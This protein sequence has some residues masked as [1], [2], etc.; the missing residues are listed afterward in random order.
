MVTKPTFVPPVW[1][2]DKYDSLAD[3][4]ADLA[5]TEEQYHS[6]MEAYRDAIWA[7]RYQDVPDI[8]T[9]TQVAPETTQ[10]MTYEDITAL[11]DTELNTALNQLPNPVDWQ[12]VAT[13][14]GLHLVDPEGTEYGESL[15]NWE[16]LDTYINQQRYNLPISTEKI[17]SFARIEQ[18]ASEGGITAK[19]REA[20]LLE[21]GLTSEDVKQYYAAIQEAQQQYTFEDLLAGQTQQLPYSGIGGVTG[22]INRPEQRPSAPISEVTGIEGMVQK[23]TNPEQVL[24]ASIDYVF[25]DVPE[26][27]NKPADAAIADIRAALVSDTQGFLD[28]YTDKG[29]STETKFVLQTAAPELTDQDVKDAFNWKDAVNFVE[30]EVRNLFPKI[31]DPGVVIQIAQDNPEQFLDIVSR[32]PN[33]ADAIDLTRL[34]L[35][36]YSDKELRTAFYGEYDEGFWGTAWDVLQRGTAATASLVNSGLSWAGT[37][38]GIEPIQKFGQENVDFYNKWITDQGIQA[39]MGVGE[40]IGWQL[41]EQ[42]PTQAL[43]MAGT[44]G[45]GTV[46]QAPLAALGTTATKALGVLGTSARLSSFTGY[47]MQATGYAVANTAFEGLFEAAGTYQQAIDAGFDEQ[48]ASNRAWDVLAHNMQLT[49]TNIPE[50]MAMLMP[51]TRYGKELESLVAKGVVQKTVGRGLGFVLTAGTEGGEE[52]FQE[53]W[54]RQAMGQDIKAWQIKKNLSDEEVRTVVYLGMAMGGIY[55]TGA[56]IIPLVQNNVLKNLK[57]DALTQAQKDIASKVREGQDYD[58][59]VNDVLSQLTDDPEV[60][61]IIDKAIEVA[62]IE[63]LGLMSQTVNQGQREAIQAT[64]QR[65]ADKIGL[66]TKIL[67]GLKQVVETGELGAIGKPAVTLKKLPTERETIILNRI[68]TEGEDIGL[69]VEAVQGIA[70]GEYWISISANQKINDKFDAYQKWINTV[71]KTQEQEEALRSFMTDTIAKIDY[72]GLHRIK[73]G[74]LPFQTIQDAVNFLNTGDI[75][76]VTKNLQLRGTPWSA[77][78]R[79]EVESA[80]ERDRFMREPIEIQLRPIREEIAKLEEEKREVREKRFDRKTSDEDYKTL[81][82]REA[83]L[84]VEISNLQ[85]QY[86]DIAFGKRPTRLEML[87]AEKEQMP[88]IEPQTLDA[89]KQANP[90]FEPEVIDYVANLTETPAEL[91]E[92]SLKTT[93]I[94]IKGG[95]WMNYTNEQFAQ[96]KEAME[97]VTPTEAQQAQQATVERQLEEAPVAKAEVIENVK[98]SQAKAKT[99]Q[100]IKETSSKRKKPEVTKP[101]KNTIKKVKTEDDKGV[102]IIEPPKITKPSYEAE[103]TKGWNRDNLIEYSNKNIELNPSNDL[104]KVSTKLPGLKQALA[105]MKPK[106]SMNTPETRVVHLSMNVESQVQ[107][108]IDSLSHVGREKIKAK[109][110]DAFGKN[111]VHGK[112]QADNRY[113]GPHEEYQERGYL[114]DVIQNPDRYVISPKQQE[115]INMLNPHYDYWL[116]YVNRNFIKDKKDRIGRFDSKPNG[117]FLPN[118]D[119]G[120]DVIEKMG[121]EYTAG[122]T[123]RGKTRYYE[124]SKDRTLHSQKLGQPY[125]PQMDIA[126]LIDQMDAFKARYAAKNVARDVL[127]GKTKLEVMEEMHPQLYENMMGLRKKLQSLKGTLSRLQDKQSE[128]IDTFLE[129]DYED[130]DLTDLQETLNPII[131][132]GKNKGKDIKAVESEIDS[133]KTD[134]AKLQKSWKTA[135]LKPYYHV[136][137]ENISFTNKYYKQDLIPVI[138]SSRNSRSN[139][140]VNFFD[141]LRR[142]AFGPDGSPISIQGV[143]GLLFDPINT[144]KVTALEVKGIMNNKNPLYPFSKDYITQRAMEDQERISRF[145]ALEGMTIGNTV[146]EYRAEWLKKIH[147]YDKFVDSMFGWLR[148]HKY[149][150]WIAKTNQLMNAGLPRMDAEI[151]AHAITSQVFPMANRVL[152]GQSPAR[153]KLLR[154]LPTS[155]SFMME[156]AKLMYETTQGFAK[157]FTGQQLTAKEKLSMQVMMTG[158]A[159]AMFACATSAAINAGDDEDPWEA[160]FDAINPNPRNGKFLCLM[161][162]DFR[163]PLGG[164]YRGLFRMMFPQKIKVS[165]KDYSSFPVPFGGMYNWIM[166]RMNPAIRTQFDLIRNADYW[167]YKIVKGGWPENLGRLLY[168]EIEGTLPLAMGQVLED[169]RL[170]KEYKILEDLISQMLGVNAINI[171]DTYFNR[172]I[173]ELGNLDPDGNEGEIKDMAWLW[174]KIARYA[175]EEIYKPNDIVKSIIDTKKIKEEHDK[176]INTELYK[177]NTDPR[178]GDT[179]ED[180][181][182]DGRITLDQYILIRDYNALDAV[183]EQEQFLIDHPELEVNPRQE[184]LTS[185]PTENAMLFLWG[186]TSKLLTE[187]AYNKLKT[188]VDEL[189]LSEDWVQKMVPSAIAPDYFEYI[190]TVDEFTASSSEAKYFLLTHDDFFEWA[191]QPGNWNSAGLKKPDD[192]V[193]VLKINIDWAA[194]DEYYDSLQLDSERE[195]F[196]AGKVTGY[197]NADAYRIATYE[198]EWYRDI[199]DTEAFISGLSEAELATLGDNPIETL[200]SQWME[201]KEIVNEHSAGSAEANLYKMKH[202]VFEK[203]GVGETSFVDWKPV[204]DSEGIMDD[205]T[206]QAH[207]Q[208][209]VDW[210]DKI[211][212]Y[213]A[214]V[215]KDE[216]DAFWAN[217]DN[218]DFQQAKFLDNTYT[219]GIPKDMRNTHIEYQN[220][221]TEFGGVSAEARY[222]RLTHSELN[223]FMKNELPKETQRWKPIDYSKYTSK[224]AYIAKL[225]IDV[226]YANEDAVYDDLKSKSERE[227]Y[228]IENP[229]YARDRRYR[230]A[231]ENAIPEEWV[232]TF[233]EYK[234]AGLTG[235]ARKSWLW[236][237][238]DFFLAVQDIM[239]WDDL[240]PVGGGSSGGKGSVGASAASLA[241]SAGYA[242]GGLLP[243][244]WY[245]PAGY[246]FER[247]TAGTTEAGGTVAPTEG[248]MQQTGSTPRRI[249]PVYSNEKWPS[250]EQKT[251]YEA[252][253]GKLQPSDADYKTL[254]WY[255]KHYPALFDAYPM[256]AT[257]IYQMLRLG[258]SPT[259]IRKELRKETVNA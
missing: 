174:G 101:K 159:F 125:T 114:L 143:L 214:L 41:L 17:E 82:D 48:D 185:H 209:Q 137:M 251:E 15:G 73:E 32:D 77:E 212:E 72:K 93:A 123:G 223:E 141:Q 71:S 152:E 130:Q 35:P 145:A 186:Q 115:V 151:T 207:Y 165:D 113:I 76:L 28:W 62:M 5:R 9:S 92:N 136:S 206:L 70:E 53:I 57:G 243:G 211:D 150:M 168:Y 240:T 67:V 42:V 122:V 44:L 199:K 58:S 132:R 191:S 81:G 245:T 208:Y 189:G 227:A 14:T 128:A 213:D 196:W 119:K 66:P 22:Y 65:R 239:E 256:Y 29:Y 153:A 232:D 106:L 204:L 178:V 210:A 117:A 155:Y 99:E 167:G 40:G 83:E 30:Q 88:T 43:L 249:E 247:G 129:S 158:A 78:R 237:H 162:G 108:Y 54:Q 85:K 170:G 139:S 19:E 75:A 236:N 1:D 198:R 120:E 49:A 11:G 33:K 4:Q 144:I 94:Q 246:E 135:N 183:E 127:N 221:V 121:S 13:P 51:L 242:Y 68:K 90:Q 182:D 3:W 59:A 86:Q 172:M 69:D 187:D 52:Y 161:V 217:P 229:T 103:P 193:N 60:Q 140:L 149:N 231:Y 220:I 105:F 257:Y 79:A 47:V 7:E 216:R 160:A 166:N 258:I 118:V 234:L 116:D 97:G 205:E 12:Y 195:K 238:Y 218:F 146:E 225:E 194:Y 171:D 10:V 202:D 154:T 228:L 23:Y 179:Y 131:S 31:A 248:I 226:T 254:E 109:L 6:S 25:W 163:I 255:R 176:Y 190:R 188:M 147:I 235:N 96:V 100:E 192:N 219:M 222:F 148:M 20:L 84:S 215:T 175:D 201:Y 104:T 55:Q 95:K 8:R 244:E 27:A 61:A 259:E 241:T 2:R 164:P 74:F 16:A 157:M 134:L 46:L 102:D 87:Q 250:G 45:F 63:Q 34:L 50:F 110:Y 80:I 26:I 39:G 24:E 138:E 197:E 21:I 142:I 177:V 224:E 89:F 233:V 107:A 98:K 126:I 36:Q 91:R 112:E 56:N 200:M 156:P 230:E 38:A 203:W 133:V 181:Y 64:L 252:E 173:K 111:V 253:T 180:Y 169:I 124:T 184:W 18:I 37:M